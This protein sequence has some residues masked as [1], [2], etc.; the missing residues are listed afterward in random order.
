MIVM[1]IFMSV[2]LFVVVCFGIGQVAWIYLDAKDRGDRLAIV[3]AIFAI[4][5]IVYPI[6]LP[7]PLIIYLL[8]SRSFSYLCPTCN[9]KV[10]KDFSTCPHC[11]QALKEKCPNC[12]KTVESEWHYCPS[13]S[14]HIK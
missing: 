4:F 3:W 9:E 5:P 10:N 12:G 14:A 8:I 1:S 13:C 11:G 6:L 7:L 2:V